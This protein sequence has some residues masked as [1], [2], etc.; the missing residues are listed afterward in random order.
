MLN[1][2]HGLAYQGAIKMAPKFAEDV[3]ET[4][5]ETQSSNLNETIPY[6]QYLNEVKKEPKVER[7]AHTRVD[8]MLEFFGSEYNENKSRKEYKIFTED[9]LHN[10]KR[11]FYGDNL[12]GKGGKDGWGVDRLVDKIKSGGENLASHK[13]I[14]L[15]LGPVGA[16]KTDIINQLARYFEHYTRLEEGKMRTWDWKNL[17]ED[18]NGNRIIPGQHPDDD[19]K[20]APMHQSPL[21]LLPKERREYALAEVEKDL[22]RSYDH[23]RDGGLVP[24]SK[25][26][27]KHLMSHYLK[28][29][30][31]NNEKEA[32]QKI[33]DNHVE[34]KRLVADE[35]LGKCIGRF[36]PRKS[37]NQD[38]SDL[39]GGINDSR[40]AI[41]GKSDPRSFDYAGEL[42]KA[43]RGIFI[44]TELL[45]G[46]DEHLY[47][48][49]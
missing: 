4:E 36:E 7:D 38:A 33:L 14:P 10:G 39:L 46:D 12:H 23:L 35:S 24:E 48:F 11:A 32:L 6:K 49:L 44:G 5:I 37:K 30:D 9:P 20:E 27:K 25:F 28:N 16:G 26:Y 47:I 13:R 40:R 21:L 43:H 1:Y 15:L 22:D 2:H 8:D 19:R 42:N 41:Y 34:V 29:G 45:K 17:Y 31:V 3:L 18:E